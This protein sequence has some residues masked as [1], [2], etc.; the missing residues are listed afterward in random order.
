MATKA[1]A[2]NQEPTEQASLST[3]I[4]SL[5]NERQVSSGAVIVALQKG[6]EAATQRYYELHTADIRVVI[7]PETYDRSATRHWHLFV[8]EEALDEE[9]EPR[10]QDVERELTVEQASEKFPGQEFNDDS[11]IVE[12]ITPVDSRRIASQ[13]AKTAINISLHQ[14]QRTSYVEQAREHNLIGKLVGGEVQGSKRDRDIRVKLGYDV[15]PGVEPVV[16]LPRSQLLPGDFYRERDFVRGV[17][18]VQEEE[19]RG[20]Q[21]ILSR[22]VPEMVA[23][24]LT[25]EV[26]EIASQTIEIKAVAREPG[27]R[28]K[29]AVRT[30]DSRIDA[31]G[32]CVGMQGLR[33]RAVQGE[34]GDEHIEIINWHPELPTFLQRAL[35]PAQLEGI[36][37]DDLQGRIVVSPFEDQQALAIGRS[38]VNVRLAEELLKSFGE[39]KVRIKSTEQY[40]SDLQHERISAVASFVNLLDFPQDVSEALA[41]AGFVSIKM[42]GE[43]SA[44]IIVQKAP[45]IDEESAG[46]IHSIAADFISTGSSGADGSLDRDLLLIEGVDEEIATLLRSA[47]YGTLQDL[48]DAEYDELMDQFDDMDEEVALDW[49]ASARQLLVEAQEQDAVASEDSESD[50]SAGDSDDTT[51]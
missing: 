31:V 36:H 23:E 25:L 47:G 11:E 15:I 37:I 49:I 30:K 28:T 41:E 50:E 18:C 39:W 34:L 45:L 16:F 8:P 35:E 2:K 51:Q 7:D 3:V 43:A 24:L 29:I 1:K 48:A 12:P 44:E 19:T 13:A 4:E 32:T 6:L 42:L 22:T 17:L 38:G 40:N 9:G 26:P 33:V 10:E 5:A 14:A 20:P 27:V 21:L 46:T